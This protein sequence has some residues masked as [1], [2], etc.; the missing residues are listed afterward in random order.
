MNFEVLE[1]VI[2]CISDCYHRLRPQE[3]RFERTLGPVRNTMANLGLQIISRLMVVQRFP[4][5]E[6][7]FQHAV[8][9]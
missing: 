4:G 7:L 6:W 8:A 1:S 3:N 2:P 9:L 5:Q